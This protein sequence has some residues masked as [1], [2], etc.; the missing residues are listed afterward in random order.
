MLSI[1]LFKTDSFI[2]IYFYDVYKI[3]LKMP[4]FSFDIKK[5]IIII[6][7]TIIKCIFIVINI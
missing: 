3:F 5:V 6:I 4:F 1:F 2:F 7:F